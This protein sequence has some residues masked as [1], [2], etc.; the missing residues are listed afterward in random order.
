MSY[1]VLYV[2][3][4]IRQDFVSNLIVIRSLIYKRTNLTFSRANTQ[5][6]P[7]TRHTKKNQNK[8]LINLIT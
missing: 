4:K 2:N 7:T 6:Y 5:H 1:F 8:D 3:G